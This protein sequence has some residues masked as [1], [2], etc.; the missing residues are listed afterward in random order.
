MSHGAKVMFFFKSL[1]C[2]GIVLIVIMCVCCCFHRNG[3][4]H[5]VSRT[6]Y[7]ETQLDLCD[8]LDTLFQ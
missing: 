8:Y 5:M 3:M 7:A 4:S 1:E 2:D 6:L